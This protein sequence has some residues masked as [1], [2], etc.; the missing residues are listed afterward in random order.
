MT[1]PY[2]LTFEPILKEK[3]WGSTRL[4]RYGKALDEGVRIGESWELAHLAVHWIF[5]AEQ[6]RQVALK[7]LILQGAGAGGNDHA[8]PLRSTGFHGIEGMYGN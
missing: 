3:V 8:P 4:A 2:A 6:P 5:A 7:Q 1:H